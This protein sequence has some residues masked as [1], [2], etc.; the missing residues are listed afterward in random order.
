MAKKIL[1]T[2]LLFIL[3]MALCS[4]GTRK[5]APP[6]TESPG[7]ETPAMEGREGRAPDLPPQE[8]SFKF[9]V[10]GDSKIL[11]DRP[12]W[13]GNVI[14]A[15]SI[16][17][18]NLE[19]TDLAIYLGDGPDRGGPANNLQAFRNVLEGLQV[20]WHTAV[21]NHEILGGAGAD[22]KKG[23]GE[24]NFRAVFADRL[25][26]LDSAGRKVSWQ[27]FDHLGSH[28]IV[29]DT[30]WQ[31]RKDGGKYR[32]APGSP[33]WEWLV[34]D[35]EAARPKSSHLFVFGHIPPV[36]PYSPGSAWPDPGEAR[37]FTG[38]CRQYRVDAVFSGHFHAY[39]SF[40][41]GDIMHIISGGG[42]A[43]LYA[44]PESGGYFHYIVCTVRGDRVEYKAVPVN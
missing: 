19:G 28:F 10:F 32:L 30:A 21:G 40:S 17:R 42:G 26:L 2:A 7:A 14:L 36:N 34:Q 23:D 15:R 24:E 16:E 25:P 3:A 37:A 4:C 35:L 11:P 5:G 44:P 6:P 22:G 38:L 29:L 8:A 13:Q 12:R 39:K 27:S 1:T 43:S 20:P 9:A 33:Q 18:I 41:D 31:A